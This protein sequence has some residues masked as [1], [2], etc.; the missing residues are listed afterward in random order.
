MDRQRKNNSSASMETE[1]FAIQAELERLKS[2]KRELTGACD[3]AWETHMT[4]SR[5][6]EE[7]L[8]AQEMMGTVVRQASRATPNPKPDRPRHL[9]NSVITGVVGFIFGFAYLFLFI[10]PVRSAF[11]QAMLPPESRSSART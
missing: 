2:R 7:L 6:L 10:G 5:K 3:L 1:I 8:L 4:V 11:I 9:F